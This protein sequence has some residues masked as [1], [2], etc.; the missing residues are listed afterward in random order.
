MLDLRARPLR[1]T[2][3]DRTRFVD[4]D[5]DLGAIARALRLGFN[6]M[7]I[8]ERGSGISS[9]FASLSWKLADSSMATPMVHY[10]AADRFDR[11]GPLLSHVA[12]ALDERAG[13]AVEDP[14]AAVDQLARAIGYTGPVVVALDDLSGSLAH[15]TFGRMRDELWSIANLQW[16]VGMSAAEE[17][18][19]L[20]PPADQFFEAVRRLQPFTEEALVEMLVQRDAGSEIS[21]EAVTDVARR[22]NGSPRRALELARNLVLDGDESPTRPSH[23][24]IDEIARSLGPSASRLAEELTRSG[25]SGPWD[26]ALLRRLGWSRPRAYEVFRLLETNGYVDVELERTGRPGRPRRLIRLRQFEL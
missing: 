21:E 4:R 22:A 18:I 5:E 24:V 12:R 3:A 14:E 2:A 1:D 13:A 9:L 26:E 16:V 8:G 23:E 7:V 15:M 19:A 10:V 11:P 25:T 17:I 6:V 20:T